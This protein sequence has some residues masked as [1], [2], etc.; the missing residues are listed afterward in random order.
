MKKIL[1][2]VSTI[3]FSLVFFVGV[4]LA[5]N[6]SINFESSIYTVGSINGQDGWSATGPYDQAVVLNTYGYTT[7]DSQSF[8]I[9]NAV[10][11]GSFGDW[12][13]SKSLANEVGETSSTNGGFSGGTR[14]P[15][16]EAQFDL[17]STVPGAEQPGLQVSIAPD[18]G[19]GSR[20][21][22]LR[23]N[24]T[25]GGINVTFADVQGTTNPANFV[26]TVIATGLNRSVPHTVRLTMDV[27]DGPSNDVVKVYIDSVLVHTGTS[28]ENYYRF[29]SEAL[30]EQSP[31]TTDSL[32][33]QARSGAG[34]APATLG[35]G[36]LFDNL[37]LS[38]GPI[39]PV[40]VGPPT[41]K[42]ECKKDGWM[43]FNN[44]T[45]KNQ[46]ACVS[47]VVSNE[48]AGKRD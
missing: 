19:D 39:P 1:L 37:S 22:F 7:F 10:T 29:D 47:Y 30:A 13:F 12:V 14:Q 6:L 15:H 42:D 5:D 3:V 25:P 35:N 48:N 2:T 18:R 17:A 23:F 27:L 45:F 41:N 32:I 38:S 31:R 24:D 44:P 34:T 40:L 28:W 26:S 8:R 36:F 16:F 20:M 43:T 33:F 4:A 11:S 9:S 46:G 21:S